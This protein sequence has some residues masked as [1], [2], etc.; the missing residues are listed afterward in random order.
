MRHTIENLTPIHK[1]TKPIKT[2]KQVKPIKTK[3]QVKP[4]KTKKIKTKYNF[5]Y[6]ICISGMDK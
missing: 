5:F 2:K 3:K 1:P 4:I 6:L